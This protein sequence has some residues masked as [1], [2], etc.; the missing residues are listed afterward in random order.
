[1]PP[2]PARLSTTNVCPMDSWN[3]FPSSRPWMSVPPP[4]PNG[5]MMRTDF[6]GQV[7]EGAAAPSASPSTT[8]PACSNCFLNIFFSSYRYHLK[9]YKSLASSTAINRI[10][11][12]EERVQDVI[13]HQV[14]DLLEAR[15]RDAGHHGELLVGVGQPLEELGEVVEARDAV[16][17]AA[18]DEGRHGDLCGIHHRQLRAHVHVGAGRHRIVERKGLVGKRLDHAVLRAPRMVPGEDAVHESAVDG[19]AVLRAELRQLL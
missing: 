13:D 18:H 7:W 2:A 5:T 9:H 3:F 14:V 17:L 12:G 6:A 4:G 19:P 10:R 11:L 1:M 15:V 8:A 16:E